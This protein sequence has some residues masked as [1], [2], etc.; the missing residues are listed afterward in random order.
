[1]K[2]SIVIPTYNHC[3]DLL[4]PCIESIKKYTDLSNVEIIIVANGCTD[5]TKSYVSSLGYPFKLVWSTD[6]LG[7]TRATNLGIQAATGQY[8]ILMNN[9]IVLLEQPTNNWLELLETPFIKDPL[10]GITGPVKFH[11]PVGKTT[12]TAMAFW[13]VMIP[14]SL[15]DQ[16]GVLDEIFSPGMGEDGDF[17]IKA[18][19]AGYKLIS[20][21]L[22]I[23]GDFDKGIENFGFPV[24][25]KGNGTFADNIYLKDDVIQRNN[26][27]LEERYGEL[28]KT[29]D[30]SIVVPTA[31]NFS[32]AL[33]PC[34]EALLAYTDLSNKEI[35]V[36][37][38]G[39]PPETREFLEAHKDVLRYVWFDDPQGYIRAVNSG[40]SNS[41]GKYVVLLDDDSILLDQPKDHWISLLQSP[42]IADPLV[43]A[44][45]P[46]ANYYEDMGLV[47]HSGCTMYNTQLLRHIGMFD[48]TYNPGYF[49]DSD[50]AMKVWNAGYKCIE[51]CEPGSPIKDYNSN[52]GMFIIYFPVCHIGHVQTMDKNKDIKIVEKNREILYNRY[53]ISNKNMNYESNLG[54]W[55]WYQGVTEKFSYGD[56]QTYRLGAQFL[57][58]CKTIEDWGCGTCYFSNF[59]DSVT[60]YK[61]IDGSHSKFVTEIHDLVQYRPVIKSDGIFM[62]HILE[63]NY[64]W[65]EVLQNALDS[66]KDKMVLV[67]FTPIN[68]TETKV[69]TVNSELG[70]P[71]IAFNIN[72]ILEF[73]KPFKFKRE[74]IRSDTQYGVEQIFYIERF[75]KIS[76]VIPTYN[77]CDDLLK[78]CIESIKRYTNLSSVEII[79]VA[80]GCTD[81]TRDYLNS[82]GEIVKLIWVDEAIGFTCATN[83]GIKAATSDYVLLL[84][85]DTEI[86]QSPVHYWLD[87]LYQPFKDDEKMALTGSLELFDGD[88]G[89]NFIVF[90]C[91]LIKRE[92]FD[93]IGLPDEI[94]SP[95][96]GE[97]ID[98]TQKVEKNGYTWKC[99]DTTTPN[100]ELRMHIGTFPL[101]HKGNQT[102]GEIPEYNNVIVQRNR[103]ILIDRYIKNE[104]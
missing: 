61:G 10:T 85:N 65:R 58:G 21:P 75:P 76:I 63:N 102:F 74:E 101:W 20:V 68:D 89:K 66:F 17:S 13:L 100:P 98:F 72:D 33:K 42:F 8:I 7:Y 27:I 77:H 104:I 97:D 30:I 5:N 2:F 23:N 70:V 41:N 31:H 54:K 6:G 64:Q 71:D 56:E 62:R 81:G 15:F 39:S 9:D 37:A 11:W 86:L 80:N 25:H 47:L 34:I 26:K 82:L 91:A 14:R 87:T 59:L 67:L 45:S 40:I 55:T 79:V 12:R 92:V 49:S 3:D 88:I 24:W 52:A 73:L 29:I 46:F 16:L 84:N 32:N 36:I 95:G 48:E 28:S 1:M 18:E 51:A 44:T 19:I 90:C 69:I 99:I 94:F 38:N 35:I 50:V 43:G 78:P 22:D 103:Q 93:V 60:S 53:R 83:L 4:K 96:Y 57:K